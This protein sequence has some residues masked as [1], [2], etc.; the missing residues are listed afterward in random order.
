MS[1]LIVK[2]NVIGESEV[3]Q[4]KTPIRAVHQYSGVDFHVSKTVMQ[5]TL[6][7]SIQKCPESD[8]NN[9]S[10]SNEWSTNQ[11]LFWKTGDSNNPTYTQCA[12]V[13]DSSSNSFIFEVDEENP[14]NIL[15]VSVIFNLAGH[16]VISFRE[17][18]TNDNLINEVV[19]YAEAMDINTLNITMPF[20]GETNQF[21]SVY[22]SYN[23]SLF[24]LLQQSGNDFKMCMF[25]NEEVPEDHIGEIHTLSENDTYIG[26][27]DVIYTV[28]DVNDS[29]NV[30]GIIVE[31]P[32]DKCY[33]RESAS[34]LKLKKVVLYKLAFRG[35]YRT[36]PQ[37]IF[38][39]SSKVY[40][41]GNT[42]SIS[43]N[44]ALGEVIGVYNAESGI[45]TIEKSL[46]GGNLSSLSG[47]LGD[48]IVNGTTGWDV[49]PVGHADE[50]LRVL[51]FNGI[52]YPT[53][54]PNNTSFGSYKQFIS[55]TY[56][57]KFNI[58]QGNALKFTE[59]YD[60]NTSINIEESG[61]NYF[62]LDENGNLKLDPIPTEPTYVI[63]EDSDLF[64]DSGDSDF[65]T[66]ISDPNSDYYYNIEL[67]D[68][69]WYF[70]VENEIADQSYYM[71]PENSLVEYS[72]KGATCL[73]VNEEND[74][75]SMPLDYVGD[76]DSGEE[77]KFHNRL[78]SA[79]NNTSLMWNIYE[80]ADNQIFKYKLYDSEK[81]EY[82]TDEKDMFA[83]ENIDSDTVVFKAHSFDFIG[84]DNCMGILSVANEIDFEDTTKLFEIVLTTNASNVYTDHENFKDYSNAVHIKIG[85]NS[86]NPW[87]FDEGESFSDDDSYMTGFGDTIKIIKHENYYALYFVANYNNSGTEYSRIGC[88]SFYLN[89]KNDTIDVSFVNSNNYFVSTKH[90]SQNF[91][92]IKNFGVE[93]I[94]K[95]HDIIL[96]SNSSAKYKLFVSNE[97][98]CYGD[99]N[100]LYYYDVNT[101][102]FSD[103][104][105]DTDIVNFSLC[106][107]KNNVCALATQEVADGFP[108][109][110]MNRVRFFVFDGEFDYTLKST[111]GRYIQSV[112]LVENCEFE[113]SRYQFISPVM[114]NYSTEDN[115]GFMKCIEIG[116]DSFAVFYLAGSWVRCTIGTVNERI[117]DGERTIDV[118]WQEIKNNIMSIDFELDYCSSICKNRL[119]NGDENVVLGVLSLDTQSDGFIT[120][121]YVPLK[122]GTIYE[123]TIMGVAGKFNQETELRN[124]CFNGES[125][126]SSSQNLNAHV[127]MNVYC[128]DFGK[129]SRMTTENFIGQYI[130]NNKIVKK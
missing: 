118:F 102:I 120:S 110:L 107:V 82:V 77:T 62:E 14:N 101:S 95:E 7:I 30:F 75:D 55:D 98:N 114:K 67:V 108:D 31:N 8:L 100:I 123:N 84:L 32:I 83:S 61:L 69:R 50:V 51:D 97:L 126:I 22:T 57:D 72:R 109:I 127:G 119:F 93:S 124:I 11:W 12:S 20:V 36:T 33:I 68:G 103:I 45:L 29:K 80:D 5:N 53:W 111:D 74:L 1:R 122:F 3:K 64:D 58:I 24:K 2:Y 113:S 125:E 28:E 81:N 117:V 38:S 52:L 4:Y 16:Y 59:I 99:M 25:E 70:I 35:V 26:K 106:K 18:N 60:T 6:K 40:Y 79:G 128:D 96:V 34:S 42:A 66:S 63:T 47:N 89:Y 56:S 116:N 87:L 112:K 73:K 37:S 76:V 41:D 88:I 105:S 121:R 130:G 49:L 17:Y 71:P 115:F 46:S 94:N 78:F 65:Y 54:M 13:Y 27:N 86:A 43:S 21:G 85:G 48:M 91:G 92:L 23:R 39:Q 10:V 15:D 129:L 19:V 9:P 104:S 90:E 44:P